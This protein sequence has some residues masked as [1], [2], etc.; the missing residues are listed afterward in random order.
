MEA[1]KLFSSGAAQASISEEYRTTGYAVVAGVFGPDELQSM[2]RAW[3]RIGDERRSEGKSPFA[4]L[5]MAHLTY[6]EIRHIVRSAG[7][8]RVVELLLG[9]KVDLI[10]SQLMFGAPG[11]KG[12]SPHQDNFYNRANP[13]DGII[14][15]W[16]ALEP[17]DQENGGVAVYPG[18]H[19]GGLV[20]T[21]RDWLYLL[22]Q[23]PDIVKSLLRSLSPAGRNSATDSGVLER[24]TYA[25]PPEGL[26][27]VTHGLAPGSVLFMHGDLI[28]SSSPNRSDR[29]RRSLLTNFVRRG[30]EFHAGLSTGR[31][32]FDV[33]AA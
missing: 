5:L 25:V 26:R 21:R 15:A 32:A 31:T 13:R 11:A 23:S 20:E 4:T 8:V 27:P 6:P 28:H 14:A 2:L 24:F 3:T 16:I 33:Y 22:S 18:S 9:G 29:F 10:Q 7:L 19:A 17:V 12:F 30:T 1:A